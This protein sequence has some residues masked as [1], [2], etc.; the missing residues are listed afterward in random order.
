[1]GTPSAREWVQVELKAVFLTPL[2]LPAIA[3]TERIVS[4]SKLF[5]N[6]MNPNFSYANLNIQ[7]VARSAVHT[8]LSLF[9]RAM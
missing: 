3:M 4:W 2:G 7:V 5:H 6:C 1:M 9:C 8:Q